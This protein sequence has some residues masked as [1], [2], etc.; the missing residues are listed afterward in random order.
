MVMVHSDTA[1]YACGRHIFAQGTM[2]SHRLMNPSIHR[3]REGVNK[4]T[5]SK[6]Y[7]L[8]PPMSAQKLAGSSYPS[9]PVHPERN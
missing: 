6:G 8:H 5:R 2:R 1:A 7:S 9:S 4:R 3:P